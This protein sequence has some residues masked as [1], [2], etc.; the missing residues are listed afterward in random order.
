MNDV[1]ANVDRNGERPRGSEMVGFEHSE[2][3]PYL[4]HDHGMWNVSA[5]G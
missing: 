1:Q 3:R 2:Q 5:H 4:T